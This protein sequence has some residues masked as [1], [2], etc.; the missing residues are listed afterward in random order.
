MKF[1]RTT[2][3]LASYL[4]TTPSTSVSSD[5]VTYTWTTSYTE[6]WSK[7]YQEEI[8]RTWDRIYKEA[9]PGIKLDKNTLII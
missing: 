9:F 7:Y 2:D 1:R 5:H 6:A 8:Q 3:N 4:T